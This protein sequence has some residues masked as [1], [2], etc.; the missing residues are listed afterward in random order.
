[1]TM[2]ADNFNHLFVDHKKMVSYDP[3]SKKVVKND[4]KLRPSNFRDLVTG[5]LIIFKKRFFKTRW[6][7]G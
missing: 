2:L 1:M 6:P 3:K 5:K 4:L 7:S